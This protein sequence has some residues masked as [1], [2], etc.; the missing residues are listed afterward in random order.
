MQRTKALKDA[1][2]LR[3]DV[4]EEPIIF[5]SD[6]A[7]AHQRREPGERGFDLR[8]LGKGWHLHQVQHEATTLGVHDEGGPRWEEGQEPRGLGEIEETR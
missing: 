8:L 5:G 4:H 2:G 3:L 1:S 6:L 7:D